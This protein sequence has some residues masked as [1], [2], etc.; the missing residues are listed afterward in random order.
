MAALNDRC[1]FYGLQVSHLDSSG[2]GG[3]GG[4]CNVY[5]MTDGP[6]KAGA[7]CSAEK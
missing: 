6:H 3:A 5:T 7:H 2:Q 1:L 4:C